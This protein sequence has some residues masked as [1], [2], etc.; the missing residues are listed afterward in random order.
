MWG[1]REKEASGWLKY[2]CFGWVAK[3]NNNNNNTINWEKE[4]WE[5]GRVNQVFEGGL[6]AKSEMCIWSSGKDGSRCL[7]IWAC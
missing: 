3:N 7:D 1:R 2:T 4:T 5:G 6:D